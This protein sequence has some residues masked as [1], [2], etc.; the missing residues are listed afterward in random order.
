MLSK[1]Y[2][3]MSVLV[4]VDL[5]TVDELIMFGKDIDEWQQVRSKNRHKQVE[6][7]RYSCE[8]R[9]ANM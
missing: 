4:L 8:D 7:K 1:V 6:V 3:F 2:T 5:S 9:K